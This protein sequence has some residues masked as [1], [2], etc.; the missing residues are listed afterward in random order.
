MTGELWLSSW[1]KSEGFFP[2]LK[3]ADWLWEAP[4]LLFQEVPGALSFL[5]VRWPEHEADSSPQSNAEIENEWN[6]AI[7]YG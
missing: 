6:Q 7:I 3:C 4:S 2:S 5:V 1:W